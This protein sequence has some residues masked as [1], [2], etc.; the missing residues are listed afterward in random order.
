MCVFHQIKKKTGVVH[1]QRWSLVVFFRRNAFKVEQYESLGRIPSSRTAPAVENNT[2]T[3]QYNI[4]TQKWNFIR[5][6]GGAGK[7][8]Q[9]K[10][11]SLVVN[12]EKILR[13]DS[14]FFSL[15][16]FVCPSRSSDGRRNKYCCFQT[17]YPWLAR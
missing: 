13:L 17:K 16:R 3:K 6:V 12:R 15:F 14:F 9:V 4:T 10:L 5:N 2:L 7:S 11:N 1:N 8:R